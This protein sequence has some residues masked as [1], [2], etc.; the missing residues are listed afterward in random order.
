L[1]ISSTTRKAGPYT[2]NAVTTAFPF[3]F[4]VFS[5]SDV[6]VISTDPTGAET[7]LSLGTN[8]TVT[9][10]SNQDSNPG[11]T[12]N[13]LIAPAVGYLLTLTSALPYLQSV[14]VTNGGGFYPAIFND[15][16]DRLTIFAQQL[17]DSVSRS[18]KISIST[19]AGVN[20]TLPSPVPYQLIGWNANG[21]GFQNTDPTYSTALATDLASTAAGKGASLVGF[22]QSGTGAVARTVQDKSIESVSV[23]DFG[24]DPTGVVDSY[25][26]WVAAIAKLPAS[27]GNI[28]VPA[29]IWNLSAK[30]SWGTK[31]IM[32]N[33]D[34]GASFTGVGSS[35][36]SGSGYFPTMN[37]NPVQVAVGPWIQ[38]QSSVASPAGGGLAAMNVEMI[39]PPGYVGQSVAL[40]TGARGSS[41]NA[42]SNV[43]SI[44]PLIQADIGA[45]GTYQCIEVDVNNFSS[46]A[47]VKGISINGVGTF[48]PFVALEV[49]RAGT[50]GNPGSS[51]TRGLDIR[52]S[53][54][55]LWINPGPTLTTGINING[56]PGNAAISAVQIGNGGDCLLLS[57]STDSSPS[58][59]LLRAVNS[60]NNSNLVLLDVVGNMSIVGI[61][62]V[63]HIVMTNP[64]SPKT[65]GQFAIG[66]SSQYTVGA[67][68][69]ASALPS[70]PRGYLIGYEGATKIVIPYYLAS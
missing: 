33:I 7:T 35:T 25:G 18:L 36:V 65:S 24:A 8:Y 26:A 48:N 64:A 46:S 45:G 58:G 68:G 59:Y 56:G 63:N 34:A 29:G 9:L 6:V 53:I 15:V 51:W 69:S 55:G 2:G 57:R 1:T 62:S 20:P 14:L 44:N 13:M 19:P 17:S 27:G 11:G 67:A 22:T 49:I 28:K 47:L 40:Y 4:K 31:S 66:A 32:W 21:D 60:A 37:T 12:V 61:M 54:T 30:P 50:K 42:S 43:W 23:L 70:A 3:S 38:S 52:D 39:Q 5:A 16:F 41:P 10:N